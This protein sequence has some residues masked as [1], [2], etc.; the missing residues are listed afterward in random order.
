MP[1]FQAGGKLHCYAHVPKCGGTSVERYLFLR[2]KRGSLH[3]SKRNMVET[4][5]RWTE[6][7]PKNETMDA[8]SAL[9]RREWLGKVL[10]IIRD[11]VKWLVCESNFQSVILRS[12][13]VGMSM[14]EW[15]EDSVKEAAVDPFYLDKHLQAHTDPFPADATIFRLEDSLDRAIPY[16]DVLA[17]DTAGNVSS[18]RKQ[19]TVRAYSA[20]YGPRPSPAGML[21]GIT[22]YFGQ[23][24]ERLGNVPRGFRWPW[25]DNA[26]RAQSACG[27]GDAQRPVAYTA[28]RGAA[29]APRVKRRGGR[30]ASSA[31]SIQG[32]KAG[33][34]VR[35]RAP[36]SPTGRP[37]F[38]PGAVVVEGTVNGHGQSYP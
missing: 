4:N 29:V 16:L 35:R 36:K 8:F 23:D 14:E 24:F 10:A 18:E 20:L 11:L 30:S 32:G 5:K 13:P 6:T 38:G 19:S 26:G 34:S 31:A 33:M 2:F 28:A 37:V 1:I 15:F 27:G 22:A 25:R 9:F 17:G 7:S 21:P 12:I 3:E